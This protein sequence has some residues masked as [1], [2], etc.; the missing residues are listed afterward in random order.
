MIEIKKSFILY[1]FL[2]TSQLFAQERHISGLF[3]HDITFFSD[4]TYIIDFHTRIAS[5]ATLTVLANTK[6]YFT[7][8]ASLVVNG[9]L[10]IKGEPRNIIEFSSLDRNFQGIGIIISGYEGKTVNIKYC[11][12]SD[13][14]IPIRFEQGW[15]REKV[16][17]SHSIFERISAQP[18]IKIEHLSQ[19]YS[20]EKCVFNFD[21]NN[22]VANNSTIFIEPLEDDVLQLKCKENLIVNNYL[23]GNEIKNPLNAAWS[24]HFDQRNRLNTIQFLDNTILNNLLYVGLDTIY[25]LNIGISGGGESFEITS[26]FLGERKKAESSLI[27][28]KQNEKLPLLLLTNLLDQPSSQTHGHIWKIQIKKEQQWEDVQQPWETLSFDKD[29]WYFAL[30]FNRDVEIQSDF[31]VAFKYFSTT[32]QKIEIISFSP[33][34]I[35]FEDK[36]LRFKLGNLEKLKSIDNGAFIFPAAIDSDGFPTPEFSFGNLQKVILFE[37]GLLNEYLEKN[38]EEKEKKIEPIKMEKEKNLTEEVKWKFVGINSGISF[39]SGDLSSDYNQ[40]SHV[41]LGLQWGYH[42]T[43]DFYLQAEIASTKISGQSADYKNLSFSSEIVEA[44]LLA[45]YYLSQLSFFKI[46]P[47]IFAGISYFHHQPMGKYNNYIYDLQQLNTE[48]RAENYALNLLSFPYGCGM[49]YH[50]SENWTVGI[51]LRF[52]KIF[53][54]YLDDVSG[55]YANYETMLQ[56]YGDAAAYFSD[57]SRS[58]TEYN[59]QKSGTRGNTFNKDTYSTLMISIRKFLR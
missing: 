57:P 49:D 1:L 34:D 18:G 4:T 15:Y 31:K 12:M 30:H 52:R 22:F 38:K 8:G 32:N 58:I 25:E 5:N 39:Y 51:S 28:F 59:Y 20:G 43:S 55:K 42:F 14:L 19:I 11:K 29:E 54:D 53:S 17:I 41:Y 3:Q 37:H 26:N 2:I 21:N 13:L 48:D 45:G 7:S 46:K 47:T 50:L 27:H 6:V 40:N 16:N 35:T 23:L 24:G 9:N 56:N 44:N 10:N 36:V 33:S